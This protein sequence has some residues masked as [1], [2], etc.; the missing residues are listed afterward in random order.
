MRVRA[1]AMLMSTRPI[2]V[3]LELLILLRVLRLRLVFV[4]VTRQVVRQLRRETLRR[5]S[6]QMMLAWV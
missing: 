6:Y 3:P 1:R 2:A 4:L 5:V